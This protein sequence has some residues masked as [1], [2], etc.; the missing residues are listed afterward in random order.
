M[1]QEEA[2]VLGRRNVTYNTE[3][4]DV[5]KIQ[6][7]SKL[8]SNDLETHRHDETIEVRGKWRSRKK[9]K[10]TDTQYRLT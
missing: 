3:E 1:K 5:F 8:Y 9:V 6:E 10:G 4:A 7:L 2:R